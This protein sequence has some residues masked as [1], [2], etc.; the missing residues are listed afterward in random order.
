MNKILA[1]FLFTLLTAC[2]SQQPATVGD[3]A[4]ADATSSNASSPNVNSMSSATDL[5]DGTAAPPGRRTVKIPPEILQKI[6]F[7]LNKFDNEGML[8]TS[9]GKRAI[10]YEYCIP[11]A[12]QAV[13]VISTIDF[14][15]E[16]KP[17][18]SGKINCSAQEVL[19]Q[20]NS[21]QDNF[22]ALIVQLAR[23]PFVKR[24]EQSSVL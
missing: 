24:I 6:G 19:V 1:I 20:G 7:D 9:D 10:I 2:V 14:S 11:R 4:V 13:S 23:L 3:D 8:A 17:D 18:T 22:K 12:Q 15:A 5:G 16:V 21:H